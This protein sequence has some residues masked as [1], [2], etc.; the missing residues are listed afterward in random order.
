[1]DYQI[2]GSV[3]DWIKGN[4]YTFTGQTDDDEIYYGKTRE[5]FELD[6]E[7]EIKYISNSIN[8]PKIFSNL[9]STDFLIVTTQIYKEKDNLQIC[10]DIDDC[11]F[12]DKPEIVNIYIGSSREQINIQKYFSQ[13]FIDYKLDNLDSM[14][15]NIA[16]KS[17]FVIIK[18]IDEPNEENLLFVQ[19]NVVMN[20]RLSK[21]I[22]KDKCDIFLLNGNFLAK[23]KNDNIKNYIDISTTPKKQQI[24][25][26][27]IIN[28][29]YENLTI[30]KKPFTNEIIFGIKGQEFLK[31]VWN[32]FEDKFYL[33]VN[34][35]IKL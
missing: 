24:E 12:S 5:S 10:V 23:R 13:T 34:E 32:K 35:Q 9:Y 6:N 2:F 7:C 19:I 21:F 27:D 15:G 20:T 17:D 16:K 22:K 29:Y 1:M 18:P 11:E 25:I 3:I 4:G 14:I 31:K 28:S 30:I 8:F 33:V 26:V